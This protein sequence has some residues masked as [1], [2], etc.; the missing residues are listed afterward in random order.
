LCFLLCLWDFVVGAGVPVS[1]YDGVA[2]VGISA[3]RDAAA[4]PKVKNAV[5]IRV[6]DFFMR[7]PNGE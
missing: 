3:A 2:G 6:A 5:L 1:A 4:K 7:S